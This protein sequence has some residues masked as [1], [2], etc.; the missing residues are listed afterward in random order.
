MPRS[1]PVVLLVRH[2]ERADTGTAAAGTDPDLSPAGHAR[3][4]ALARLLKDASITAIYTTELKRTQQTAAPLASVLGLQPAVVPAARSADLVRMVGSTA[5]IVLVVGHSNTVPDLIA[6]LGVKEPV[7]IADGEFDN[8]FVA[9]GGAE[10][11]LLR[12]R[13]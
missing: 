1:G 4:E 10:A 3:A 7:A 6:A 11:T 12:L 5:G 2:A 8:L 13:Y 9:V